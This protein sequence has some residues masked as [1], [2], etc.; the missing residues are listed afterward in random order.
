VR[1]LLEREGF[2]VERAERYGMLYRH[3]P[4]ALSR[5]LSRE[6]VLPLAVGGLRLANAV[7][8]RFGNK[9]AVVAVRR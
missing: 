6:H 4:G 7:A 9:L 8:G 1:D 2:R 5:A 3:E